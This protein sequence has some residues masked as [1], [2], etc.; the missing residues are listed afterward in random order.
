[1]VLAGFAGVGATVLVVVFGA[2]FLDGDGVAATSFFIVDVGDGLV[3]LGGAVND[4]FV[5]GGGVIIHSRKVI[6][7]MAK[8]FP[9]PPGAELI[10][11]R[12]TLLIPGGILNITLYL[13]HLP[14][15]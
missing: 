14:C 9:H 1:M 11:M 6:S 8:S 10:M 7:S 13:A 3:F 15:S 4:F 12:S 5:I 2:D